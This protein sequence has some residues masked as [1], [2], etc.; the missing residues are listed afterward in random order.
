MKL[1]AAEKHNMTQD[2]LRHLN[3]SLDVILESFVPERQIA[4]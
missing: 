1:Q 2:N 4:F 3:I